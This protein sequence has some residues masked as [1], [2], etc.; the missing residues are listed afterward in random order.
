[1]NTQ[2]LAPWIQRREGALPAWAGP[3]TE[4]IVDNFAGGGG[5][6]VG[7]EA[8]IGRCVDVAINHDREAISI[9]LP[10]SHSPLVVKYR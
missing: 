7:I 4:L 10:S 2:L 5:A 1:M 3:D 6:S 9:R 8:A